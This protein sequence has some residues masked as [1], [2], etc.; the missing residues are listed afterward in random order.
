MRKENSE[1]IT[2]SPLNSGMK[3]FNQFWSGHFFHL[4]IQAF[5]KR[6]ITLD[7]IVDVIREGVCWW[8][9]LVIKVVASVVRN[10]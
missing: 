7:D 3:A 4:R 9:Y 1:Y 2:F 5:D 6:N 8:K 10:K